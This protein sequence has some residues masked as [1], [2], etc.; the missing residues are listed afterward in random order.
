MM[1]DAGVELVERV[2]VLQADVHVVHQF[3]LRQAIANHLQFVKVARVQVLAV[4]G[5]GKQFSDVV[6]TEPSNS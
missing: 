6:Q 5:D 2:Q 4:L 1:V 3:G